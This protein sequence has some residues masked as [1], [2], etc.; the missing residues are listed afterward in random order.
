MTSS[1]DIEE[2]FEEARSELKRADHLVYVSLKYTRTVDV[3]RSV[4]DRLIACYEN[5][6]N[7]LLVDAK[8]KGLISEYPNGVGMQID[9]LGKLFSYDKEIVDYL[10]LFTLLRK[11]QKADYSRAE[12]FRRHVRM[13]STLDTGEV[14]EIKIDHVTEYYHKITQLLILIRNRVFEKRDD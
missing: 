6:C 7:I 8:K 13:I 5:C 11:L 2:L 4:I 9:F 12:E 10:N 14:M 1:L 3:L